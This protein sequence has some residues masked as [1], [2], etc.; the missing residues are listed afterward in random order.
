VNWLDPAVIDFFPYTVSLPYPLPQFP[1]SISGKQ[2]L[3][4][5]IVSVTHILVQKINIDY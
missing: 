4:L 2:Q 5:K 3:S 1:A